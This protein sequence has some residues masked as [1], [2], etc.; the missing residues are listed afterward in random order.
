ML[1]A[2]RTFSTIFFIVDAA[3]LSGDDIAALDYAQRLRA[4]RKFCTAVNRGV[5]S[6]QAETVRLETNSSRR[7]SGGGGWRAPYK[8][9]SF[10]FHC[11]E[12]LDVAE[13]PKR[14]DE[15][16]LAFHTEKCRQLAVADFAFSADIVREPSALAWSCQSIR[17]VQRFKGSPQ[18]ASLS[19]SDNHHTIL[20]GYRCR[21]SEEA[22]ALFLVDS[23]NE[24]AHSAAPRAAA[25]SFFGHLPHARSSPLVWTWSWQM[26]SANAYGPKEILD[27]EREHTLLT[28]RA[29][30][31]AVAARIRAYPQ[32]VLVAQLEYE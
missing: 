7:K 24:I 12:A 14:L 11:A 6:F 21:W 9:E 1:I 17:F 30:Q 29:F 22:R 20:A 18:L 25:A 28:R 5:E 26:N 10:Y 23:S 32:N 2:D 31:D 13:L 27:D 19:A 15:L 8:L 16:K 4:A 3:V